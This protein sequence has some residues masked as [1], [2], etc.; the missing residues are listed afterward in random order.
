MLLHHWNEFFSCLNLNTPDNENTDL[1]D[2]LPGK[3]RRQND[4]DASED[5]NDEVT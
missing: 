4:E 5:D 3:R 2:A 1:L